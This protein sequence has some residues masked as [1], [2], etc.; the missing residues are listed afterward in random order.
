M[1]TLRK[2]WMVY[3]YE[4]GYSEPWF[5][6]YNEEHGEPIKIEGDWL[7]T[8]KF[9]LGGRPPFESVWHQSFLVKNVKKIEKEKFSIGQNA[10]EKV[11]IE[12]TS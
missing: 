11:E 5:F 9:P 1:I 7:Y 4:N 2:L 12:F 3:V 8:N 10:H 6:I